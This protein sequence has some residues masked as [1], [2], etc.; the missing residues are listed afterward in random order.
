VQQ[1]PAT[2]PRKVISTTERVSRGPRRPGSK[3]FSRGEILVLVI[4]AVVGAGIVIGSY[5]YTDATLDD[6]VPRPT[7]TAA[8]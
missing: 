5:F 6:G 8:P 7:A 2:D 1:R 3:I 4:A